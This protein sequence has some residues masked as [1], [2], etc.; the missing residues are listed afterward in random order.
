MGTAQPG[1]LITLSGLLASTLP[2]FENS[3]VGSLCLVCNWGQRSRSLTLESRDLNSRAASIRPTWSNWS[4]LSEPQ[5][6]I[7]KSGVPG[8]GHQRL[9]KSWPLESVLHFMAGKRV[10]FIL[11]AHFHSNP[12]ERQGQRML[13]LLHN[14]TH[15]TH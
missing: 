13:K 7:W 2:E 10:F 6:P 14:C 15:L 8:K 9:S 12:K 4:S 11:M 5:L 1:L 3:M